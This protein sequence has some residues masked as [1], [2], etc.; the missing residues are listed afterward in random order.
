MA[1]V[2]VEVLAWAAGRRRRMRIDGRSMVPTLDDGDHVL[3]DPGRRPEVGDV[4]AARPRPL[5]GTAVVK[6]VT[7]VTGDGG[8]LLASDNRAEGSEAERWGVVPA[9]RIDG[10]VTVDLGRQR[11]VP[12]LPAP[13]PG[14]EMPDPGPVEPG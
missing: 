7:M 11:R 5:A 14:D 8:C 12:G 3:V 2:V 6:R 1:P 4:V 13:D 10:V 9:D